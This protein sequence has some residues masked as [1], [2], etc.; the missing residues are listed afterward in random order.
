MSNVNPWHQYDIL[1][2]GVVAVDD[3]IYLDRFP[4]PDSKMVVGERRREGGGLTATALVA[5]SRLGAK[6]A[7]AAM[8]GTDELSAWSVAELEREGVD[9]SAVIRKEGVAPC[10]S[11]ILVVRETGQRTILSGIGGMR[12][13]PAEAVTEALVSS[14]KVLFLDHTQGEAGLKAARLAAKLGIPVVADIESARDPGTAALAAAAG[15]LIASE[16]YARDVC[17]AKG[18]GGEEDPAARLSADPAVRLSADPAVR[19]SAEPARAVAAMARPDRACAAVTA[20]AKGCWY[21]ESGGPVV[22]VPAYRVRA[23]D[24]TGCGDVFHGAYAAVI[25]RGGGVPEAISVATAA[26]AI[27]ATRPGGRSGIPGMD[28][29]GAFMKVNSKHLAG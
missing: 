21:S 19:L 24:T 17:G 10:H 23:V 4:S 20:G 8:L 29:V 2:I 13:F 28:E 16:E 18:T 12:S 27:K 22:H 5:A 15:H 25:S 9:C 11:T 7:Y 1:G 6:C 26:A 14:A 3:I